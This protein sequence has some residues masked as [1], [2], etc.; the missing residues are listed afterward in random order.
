MRVLPAL[1]AHP[2]LADRARSVRPSQRGGDGF[3]RD[4]ADVEGP[5]DADR[6]GKSRANLVND[7]DK[8]DGARPRGPLKELVGQTLKPAIWAHRGRG[9]RFGSIVVS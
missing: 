6:S 8:Y 9:S 1:L 7:P 2:A 5:E 4:R 3:L